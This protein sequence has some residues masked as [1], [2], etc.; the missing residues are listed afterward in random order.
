MK[1]APVTPV[2]HRSLP[3]QSENEVVLIFP[4]PGG[5]PS[6]HL[7]Q[8]IVDSKLVQVVNLK[9]ILLVGCWRRQEILHN[10]SN[11]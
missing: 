9:A 8:N 7:N 3:D 6:F 2:M 4:D 11:F 5:Q 1:I 10:P